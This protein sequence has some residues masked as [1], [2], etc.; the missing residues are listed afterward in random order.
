MLTGC[1]QRGLRGGAAPTAAQ[2][3]RDVPGL[4]ILNMSA[5]IESIAMESLLRRSPE[6]VLLK[7][8]TMEE[9]MQR[10]HCLLERGG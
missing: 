4:K 10:V 8:F 9:L 5:A 7:P 6:L 1:E 2:L 3:G